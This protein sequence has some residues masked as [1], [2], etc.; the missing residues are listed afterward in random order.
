ML[1]EGEAHQRRQQNHGEMAIQSLVF[2]LFFLVDH[3]E[4]ALDALISQII[5]KGSGGGKNQ[6]LYRVRVTLG[7][8]L[9]QKAAVGLAPQIHIFRVQVLDKGVNGICGGGVVFESHGIIERDE[10]ILVHKAFGQG[11]HS[12][13]QAGTAGEHHQGHIH[14]RVGIFVIPICKFAAIE[15]NSLSRRKLVVCFKFLFHVHIC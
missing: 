11:K 15:P 8:N 14:I 6:T 2:L 3:F 12:V 13:G 1:F 10:G 5:G 7:D 4:K 9:G